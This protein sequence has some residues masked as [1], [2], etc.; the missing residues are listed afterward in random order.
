MHCGL[1][2]FFLFEWFPAG[3]LHHH[4]ELANDEKNGRYWQMTV[5]NFTR[6][7]CLSQSFQWKP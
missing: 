3:A 4:T 5:L 1:F 2:W 6:V 7:S